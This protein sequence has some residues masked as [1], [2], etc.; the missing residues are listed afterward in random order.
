VVTALADRFRQWI[1]EIA[2]TERRVVYKR[3]LLIADEHGMHRSGGLAGLIDF[4]CVLLGRKTALF[5]LPLASL[6]ELLPHVGHL[7]KLDPV[8]VRR[9][10]CHFSTL[11]SVPQVIVIFP[12]KP[13]SLRSHTNARGQA[14]VP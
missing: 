14:F 13:P 10:A 7:F 5:Q 12:H 6:S 9:L 4:P 2:V 1:T 8:G 3:G 11:G